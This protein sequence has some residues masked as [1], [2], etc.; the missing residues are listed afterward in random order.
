MT[1]AHYQE[2]RKT[3][4]IL[5]VSA[6]APVFLVAG[7]RLYEAQQVV[8]ITLFFFGLLASLLTP[9]VL[10]LRR[11]AGYMNLKSQMSRMK[12]PRFPHT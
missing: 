10:F 7:L 8:S 6:L 1:V 2:S 5:F 3:R 9:L 12:L 4:L 11:N